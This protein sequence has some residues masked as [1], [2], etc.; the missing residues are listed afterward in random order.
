MKSPLGLGKG[1]GALIPGNQGTPQKNTEHQDENRIGLIDITKIKTNP[2]QP[3]V[4]FDQAAMEELVDSIKL[5]G[6][7][8]PITVRKSIGNTYELISGERRIRASIE[9]GLEQIPAFIMDVDSNEAMIELAI[10]ENVQRENLNDIEV[11][12]G[13]QLLI[14]QCKL[15]QEEVAAK[16]GKDRATV[17]NFLRLLKLPSEIQQHVAMKELSNGHARALLSLQS[18]DN[19]RLIAQRI[20]VEQLSVRQTEDIIRELMGGTKKNA[21]RT[22]K[23]TNQS[24]STRQPLN[25]DLLA[26]EDA[27]RE[28]FTTQVSIHLKDHET[29]KVEITFFSLDDLQRVIE[30]IINKQ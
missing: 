5:H 20:I 16:V 2:F 9:V 19:Q 26:L 4:I 30:L 22:A 18:P 17:A 11:A 29:G 8:Q 23:K 10:I 3:R 13:Y 28:Y 21:K 14:D 15:T 1:L 24:A 12:M 7:I 25:N 6:V 27:L